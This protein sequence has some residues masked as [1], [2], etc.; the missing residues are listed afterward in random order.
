MESLTFQPQAKRQRGVSL[1]MTLG[2]L[3]LLSAV[4]LAFLARVKSERLVTD[5]DVHYLKAKRVADMGA[6][7]VQA[8]IRAA[9]ELGTDATWASQPG[10]IRTYDNKGLLKTIYKLYSS[11]SLV[12]GNADLLV[13]DL[14]PANWAAQPGVWVDMNAPSLTSGRIV[15]P[16]VDPRAKTTDPKTSVVGF[17]YDA[18]VIAGGVAPIA[19]G[20]NANQQR[21]PMPVRWLYV[22]QDG[23]MVAPVLTNSAMSVPGAKEDNP[24]VAR[25]AYWTDDETAKININTAAGDEWGNTTSKGAYWDWPRAHG[26]S[27]RELAQHQPTHR[28]FQRYPGHPGTTYFSAIFPELTRAD[29]ATILPRLQL[30]G[31]KGGTVAVGTA[32]PVDLDEDRLFASVDELAFQYQDQPSKDGNRT[33]NLTLPGL[34]RQ[35]LERTGFFLTARSVAPE[36]N[37]F[38]LPRV[39]LWP[40]HEDDDPNNG[41]RTPFD[42]L[43]AH[44]ASLGG[45]PYYFQRANADSPVSDMADIDRNLELFKYLQALMGKDVPGYG[46]SFTAKYPEDADQILFQAVDYIRS[47]NLFDEIHEV[48][49]DPKYQPGNVPTTGKQFTDGRLGGSNKQHHTLSGHGQ[50]TPLVLVEKKEGSNDPALDLMGFGRYFTLSEVGLKFVATASGRRMPRTT[51][52]LVRLDNLYLFSNWT[53]AEHAFVAAQK[54]KKTGYES[55]AW[56]KNKYGVKPDYGAPPVPPSPPYP[57]PGKWAPPG[58]YNATLDHKLAMNEVRVEAILVME[59]FNPSPG[60]TTLHPN[61]VVEVEGLDQAKL[62]GQSLGFPKLGEEDKPPAETLYDSQLIAGIQSSRNWGGSISPRYAL[63]N[64]RAPE[65]ETPG[66]QVLSADVGHKATNSYPFISLPVTATFDPAT[67]KGTMEL[68]EFEA[69][70]RIYALDGSTRHLVQSIKLKFPKATIPTPQLRT[71][72]LYFSSQQKDKATG[73]LIPIDFKS[74]L[75]P[76]STWTVTGSSPMS[77]QRT[78]NGRMQHYGKVPGWQNAA[79]KYTSTYSDGS[80]PFVGSLFQNEDVVRTLV[81]PHGDYRLVAA[82]RNVP[83]TVFQP[84]KYYFESDAHLAH[85]FVDTWRTD[86]IHGNRLEEGYISNLTY[87]PNH[88]P[89]YPDQ[90]PRD[91]FNSFRSPES[92]GDFDNALGFV[93]DGPYIN[94]PDEGNIYQRDGSSGKIPYFDDGE[95]QVGLGG[96]YFSPN[97]IMPSAVMLG[98]LPTGVKDNSPWQ[99]LLFRPDVT[100]IHPGTSDPP[101]HVLLDLFWMPVVEP[102]AISEPL[103]TA[104]KVN[105]NYA[106]APFSYIRRSTALQAVL[107]SERIFAIPDS[108][109]K[110]YKDHNSGSRTNFRLPIDVVDEANSVKTGTLSQLESVFAKNEIFRSASDVCDLHFVPEGKTATGMKSFWSTHRLTGDN[111]KERPYAAVYPRLTTKSNTFTA[112]V[113]A[114]SIVKAKGTDPAVFEEGRD[115]VRAEWRGSYLL[116]RY[117]DANRT[118]PDFATEKLGDVTLDDYYR[119]RVVSVREF[120][121]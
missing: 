116:E 58:G 109:A 8:Q 6:N 113:V 62:D 1:L 97:R 93:Q 46:A 69:T 118:L 84:H 39:A 52:D 80:T 14:P 25:V 59:F 44:C 87:N 72:L 26:A 53:Q 32:Q 57:P 111:S 4:V 42:Q 41:Y 79:N 11:D 51:N 81:V 45:F 83:E 60:Y 117:I 67:G 61:F 15:F 23:K 86:W 82:Q 96:G 92:L 12:A 75:P 21:L 40:I 115:Q 33:S 20:S 28:E 50:V 104:G 106:I 65:R 55:L 66:G 27:E 120:N 121:P 56:D 108:Q 64:K 49:A 47:I 114:Q 77:H 2:S 43:I 85:N 74:S 78:R 94:K 103:A 34:T 90:A 48:L 17:D 102:Y 10:A 119:Q 38:N 24:I 91:S 7:V 105:L 76:S 35:R 54:D 3:V 71:A 29:L 18:N 100:G 5:M 30:G 98:S 9:T 101:D 68:N 99:T 31:S 16:I 22:L 73:E 63:Y 88:Q 89:D 107:R 36:V 112:H 70:V 95:R 110:W 19:G 37:L 13:N